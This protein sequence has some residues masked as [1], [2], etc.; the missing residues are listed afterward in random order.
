MK[1]VI[2]A[3]GKGTRIASLNSEVPKPM[4]PIAGKPVLEHQIDCLRSQGI[5]DI[6]LIIGHLGNVVKEYFQ[7]SVSYITESE[8]LGTAGALYYLNGQVED[9]FLLIHGDVIFDIDV[10]RFREFHLKRGGLVTVFT[11]PNDHPYDSGIVIADSN[12]KVTKW[13]SKEDERGWYKNRV[14]AGLHMMSPKLLNRFTEARKTD[15]DRDILKPLISE[16]SLFAYDSPEY[17]KDMG[18]PE[19]CYETERDILTG[20]VR[21]KNL[22]N[23]QKALFI[24][25]D[26]TINKFAG[27]LRNIDNFELIENTTDIIK[28]ANKEG[29]LVI[30]VTNQPVIARGEL[31]WPQLEEIHNKMETLLGQRGAYVDDIFIC[32]HHPDKGFEGERPEYKISCGCRKPK[33]GLLLQAARKYNID[34]SRSIMLGDS[35]KDMLA[36]EAAGCKSVLIDHINP[37][38]VSIDIL[39]EQ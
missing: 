26:G 19:R 15:L 5:T 1:A 6:Q 38:G 24:D 4:I 34:L 20:K 36:G 9:D 32:P 31:T 16:N 14:N 35:E 29:Y 25:R 22:R 2:M 3:G 21:A 18:T 8:P 13:L 17:V 11:H 12:G 30:V 33:P 23:K 27:F 28:A 7:S 37:S 39:K 10:E